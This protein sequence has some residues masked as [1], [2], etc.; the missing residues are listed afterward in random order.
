MSNVDCLTRTQKLL[1]SCAVLGVIV[2]LFGYMALDLYGEREKKL[3]SSFMNDASVGTSEKDLLERRGEPLAT[4]T[5][6]EEMKRELGARWP[7]PSRE[8][9][10]KVHCFT[11]GRVSGLL[12]VYV[13]G[14]GIVYYVYFMPS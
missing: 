4:F 14:E 12:L 1:M 3:Y 6:H 8:V 11:M 10:G 7:I 5:S 13:D 9:K 2:V